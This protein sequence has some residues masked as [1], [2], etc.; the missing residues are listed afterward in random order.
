[1]NIAVLGA[2]A[3]GTGMAVRL[4]Q[5]HQV[6]LY[7]R[8][9]EFIFR[10]QSQRLNQAYLPQIPLP[11]ALQL[12]GDMNKVDSADLIVLAT[13]SHAIAD[14]LLA[15]KPSK[16][17]LSLAK[18]Y[19][20]QATDGTHGD[21][22]KLPH[23]AL[24]DYAAPFAVLTG[25]SFAH[26]VAQGKPVAM[27]LASRDL[28]WAK[29][30]ASALADPQMRLYASDDIVGAEL[31]GAF[32]N[33]IAIAAGIS[34]GLGLGD[35]A[36]AALI[37]RGLAEMRRFVLAMGG[38][39]D[40]VYGLAGLG[41]L[42][43][44]CAGNSSRNRQVGLA[45]AKGQALTDILRHLGHVAEGVTATPL[46]LS[47]AQEKQIELPIVAAVADVLHGHMGAAEAI[48]HLLARPLGAE[49]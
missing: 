36:R 45:L 17:L 15:L 8:N 27:V 10:L 25:P 18:G 30:M 40:T 2:G 33:T 39:A 37:T 5:H 22:V 19:F 4:S 24:V 31:G 32:K 34:D 3:W 20:R 7:A 6:C 26:E 9:Q 49:Q 21:V 23:Q 38:R 35:N 48:K 41:D 43:L 14:L 28:A 1:M 12:S 11:E 46:T 44:T 47:L 16:P 42:M 29:T 13:P